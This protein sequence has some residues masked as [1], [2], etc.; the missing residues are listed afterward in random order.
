MVGA[1]AALVG[2]PSEVPELPPSP[3]PFWQDFDAAYE[4][5]NPEVRDL[6]APVEEG[7]LAGTFATYAVSSAIV[8]TVIMG[9]QKGGGVD[10]RLTTRT[11]DDRGK[12]YEETTVLCDGYNY[13]VAGVSGDPDPSAFT[14]VP[15]STNVL[16]FDHERGLFLGAAHVQLWGIK[17]LDDPATDALPQSPAEA[18][19]APHKDRVYDMD[20]DGEPG[21]TVYLD[22]ELEAGDFSGTIY[23]IQRKIVVAAGVA[24]D[25]G[26]ALGYL[27]TSWENN[28][29]ASDPEALASIF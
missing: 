6:G 7:A 12:K 24:T 13:E 16:K 3:S 25:E 15:P 2:C 26:R 5:M 23:A 11:W 20:E 21:V 19:E 18:E 9:Q 29:L 28:P 4:S 17:D 1:C 14:K 8:D 27:N 10:Y 22:G